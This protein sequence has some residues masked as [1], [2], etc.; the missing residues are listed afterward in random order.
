MRTETPH[1]M[2]SG[3]AAWLR[4]VVNVSHYEG[5]LPYLQVHSYSLP[6]CA[7]SART[8]VIEFP[9]WNK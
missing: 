6:V 4:A 3:P 1:E 9:V 8:A 5:V 2:T 7:V